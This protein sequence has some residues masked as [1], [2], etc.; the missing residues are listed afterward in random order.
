MVI[1]QDVLVKNV[2]KLF[3]VGDGGGGVGDMTLICAC[4]VHV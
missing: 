3:M 4:T 1:G 2:C